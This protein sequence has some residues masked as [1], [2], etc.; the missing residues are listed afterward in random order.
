MLNKTKMFTYYIQTYCTEH[1]TKYLVLSSIFV[2]L[3]S[4][5]SLICLHILSARLTLWFGRELKAF[6]C[7]P[8]KWYRSRP[9]LGHLEKRGMQTCAFLASRMTAQ[10]FRCRSAC[11]CHAKYP[12]LSVPAPLP[13][14]MP[15]ASLRST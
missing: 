12:L 1:C 2:L 9:L 15:S 5:F 7:G 10:C 14:R 6:L 4:Y 13:S 11:C 3:L 8:L